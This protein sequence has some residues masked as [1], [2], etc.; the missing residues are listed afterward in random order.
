MLLKIDIWIYALLT[1]HVFRKV[2]SF[3][4]NIA[5][6]GVVT[7][8][9]CNPLVDRVNDLAQGVCSSLKL[10]VVEESLSRQTEDAIMMAQD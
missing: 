2:L 10:S 9:P 8:D 3:A 4:K 6:I 5:D 1:T 7:F